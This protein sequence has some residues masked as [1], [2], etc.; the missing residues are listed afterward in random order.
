MKNEA[1]NNVTLTDGGYIGNRNMNFDSGTVQLQLNH[2][3]AGSGML[4]MR[5]GGP[6]GQLVNSY[7]IADTAG[8]TVTAAFDHQNDEIIYGNNGGNNDLYFVYKGTGSLTLNSFK[9]VTP[10]SSGTVQS[11]RT[12]GGSYLSDIYGNAEK[13]GDNV[14]LKGDSSEV[15]YR[16]ANMGSK[17]DDRRFMVLR[18]KSNEPVVMKAIDLAMEMRPSIP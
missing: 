3:A 5:L 7:P 8:S 2:K 12:Q 11:T 14:V 16:N 15:A 10:S 17:G 6:Q 9:Y 4:E 1:A 18:V 13:V